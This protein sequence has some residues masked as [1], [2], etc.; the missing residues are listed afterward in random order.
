MSAADPISP[1]RYRQ[2][3][4]GLGAL[5]LVV[6]FVIGAAIFLPVVQNDL[7]RRVTDELTAAGV[8]DVRVSFSGQ[9]GR[10]TCDDVLADPNRVEVLAEGVHGVRVIDLDRSCSQSAVPEPEAPTTDVAVTEPPETE[11]SVTEP[12]EATMTSDAPAAT[13]PELDTIVGV[14]REEPL[15]RKLARLLDTA[16]LT[17]DDA[18]GG[19]GPFTLFA[20]TDAAFDTMFNELGADAFTAFTSDPEALRAVLL[21]HVAE[22][23][24]TSTD[25]VAGDLVMLDGGIVTVDP[26]AAGGITFTSNGVVSRVNDPATQLDIA[27]SNGVVHAIDRLLIPEGFDLGAVTGESITSATIADGQITLSGTVQTDE[28]RATLVTSAHSQVDPANVIDELVVDGDAKIAQANIDRLGAVVAALA[29]N[30]VDGEVSLVGDRVSLSGTYLNDDADAALQE[31]GADQAAEV[32]LITRG[33]A[34]A[35]TAAALQT[36]LNDFVREN[37]ILFEAN[38]AQLTAESGA[39]VEQLAA[40]AARLD[41]TTIV[42]VGHTD[43]DGNTATNQ[44]LS[45]NRAAAVLDALV[46]RGLDAATMSSDGRGSTAPVT[47]ESGTEDKAA[48]RR[49]EFEVQVTQ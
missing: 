14:A 7:K 9:D 12:A 44:R 35:T 4:I 29:P 26:D 16:D 21:H 2:R 37:P 42:V 28:Q 22:G 20:P 34:D 10:L 6:T 45:E 18:L 1:R 49:V 8:T 47:D 23:A 17:G 5:L 32:D 39:V 48:S 13:L 33:V 31:V 41:G 36:E 24:I 30:L 25:F 11:P 40:R 46:A 43:S 15:F 38:S 3:I 27:A 19:D